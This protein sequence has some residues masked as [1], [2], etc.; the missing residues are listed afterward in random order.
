MAVV[1]CSCG[2]V[3]SIRPAD[4]RKACIRCGRPLIQVAQGC[5]GAASNHNGIASVVARHGAGHSGTDN[6]AS[7]IAWV[8]NDTM[9]SF[10][11]I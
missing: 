4:G 7:A 6:I 11:T 2:M 8:P 9:A 1:E 5:R 10:E 3:M